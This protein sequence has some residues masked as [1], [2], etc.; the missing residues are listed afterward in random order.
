M[1]PALSN[2]LGTDRTAGGRRHRNARTEPVP[3]PTYDQYSNRKQMDDMETTTHSH[4]VVIGA[5]IGGLLAA[6]VTSETFDRV[7]I[8][9]RD[10]LPGIPTARRCVPHARHA[11]AL[12]AR[13]LATIEELFPG[14][15][16]DL[17]GFGAPTGDG[18]SDFRWVFDGHRWTTGISGVRLL[19]ASRPLIEW[20]LRTLVDALPNVEILDH[21][22]A[23]GIITDPRRHAI[24]GLALSRT[25][26]SRT[27]HRI[28]DNV[29]DADLI[30]DAS[31]RSS[32]SQGWLEP[33][34]YPRPEEERLSIHL[35]YTTRRYRREPSQIDGDLGIGIGTT[36]ALP[37]GGI[38]LAQENKSW[39]IT[40][41][42][43]G[44]DE[45]PVDPHGF[46]D[47]ARSLPAPELGDLISTAEPID[48]GARY[49]VPTTVRRHFDPAHLPRGYLP[50]GDTICSFNPVYG[51]GMSVAALEALILRDCLRAN[52]ARV[53]ER[54]LH[55]A[56]PLLDQAWS[57]SCNSDLRLPFID[58]KRTTRARATNA[59]VA[60]VHRAA[61]TDPRVGTAFLRVISLLDH[62][63]TL[64]R[65]A[66]L[67]R[68]L[69]ANRTS[70]PT[71]TAHTSAHHYPAGL[72][73]APGLD[74]ASNHPEIA[75]NCPTPISAPRPVQ[76]EP[77]ETRH[78]RCA[79]R[80]TRDAHVPSVIHLF[81]H[82][83]ENGH[84][85][86]S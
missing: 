18:Q 52:G 73:P 2:R 15:T 41:A 29:L 49:R 7:T 71:N 24:T 17:V 57:M 45:P 65:P 68:V 43:Y 14:F 9:E 81:S 6:R 82:A 66:T 42:G 74:P 31:G 37:R 84:D 86:N 53:T 16:D 75:Y 4:A 20:H 76:D 72:S 60:R 77:D 25:S 34:G 28:A 44:D 23:I 12:T 3:P 67:T 61:A 32:Q 10:G 69:R 38:A 62:P 39:I 50:F 19:V 56:R 80:G 59:Y 33:L 83:E 1:N 54:F 8:V 26:H 13:G 70:P 64:L 79:G 48:D 55:K 36:P 63:T 27:S 47:F 5:G 58:G 21:C 51:Q 40:L 46:V 78:A 85:A 35:T 22:A 11:H 30:V